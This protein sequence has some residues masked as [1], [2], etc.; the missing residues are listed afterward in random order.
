MFSWNH[1]ATVESEERLGSEQKKTRLSLYRNIR[2]GASLY[3][4]PTDPEVFHFVGLE[5]EILTNL[6][7]STTR[8]A[9]TRFGLEDTQGGGEGKFLLSSWRPEKQPSKFEWMRRA[10]RDSSLTTT[11]YQWLRVTYKIQQNL[12]TSRFVRNWRSRR[13]FQWNYCQGWRRSVCSCICPE[14]TATS[15]RF[16]HVSSGNPRPRPKL[17]WV[18]LTQY[19][20]L[21]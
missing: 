21:S 18:E 15:T 17:S 9:R 14:L 2:A 10:Y 5:S 13:Y 12:Y 7:A 20:C 1:L 19:N 16:H 4:T 6:P 3:L 11:C 8:I